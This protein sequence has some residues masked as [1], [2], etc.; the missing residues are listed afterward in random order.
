MTAGQFLPNFSR[1][2]DPAVLPLWDLTNSSPKSQQ[3]LRVVQGLQS[4]LL[5]KVRQEDRIQDQLGLDSK[6]KVCSGKGARLWLS[7]N[8][9]RTGPWGWRESLA[10]EHGLLLQRTCTQVPAP[11]WRLHTTVSNSSPRDQRLL[12]HQVY[13]HA[14]NIPA[15]KIAIYTEN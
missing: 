10:E 11:T 6:S 15:G 14:L 1:T 13:T 2:P 4:Q 7:R 8:L 5:G 9:E 3:L 12:R